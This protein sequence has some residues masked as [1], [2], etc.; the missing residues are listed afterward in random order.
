MLLL[1][2]LVVIGVGLAI[3]LTIRPGAWYASLNKP[4]F[5]PPNWIFGPAWTM[6]YILIAIAG[7]RTWQLD[8]WSGW[9]VRLWAG[10]MMLNWLWTPLFFGAHAMSLGLVVI[11]CLLLTILGFIGVSRDA[12]ARICFIP[13]ALWVGFASLLNASLL[14]L[15]G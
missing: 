4:S 13:Y 8:G 14:S 12:I 10:Q 1:F 11:I 3:G 6:L 2:L 7:W 9:P 5:N 15:N